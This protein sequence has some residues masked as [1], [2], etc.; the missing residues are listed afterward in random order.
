[1]HKDDLNEDLAE[2]YSRVSLECKSYLES[3]SL[4]SREDT[5]RGLL[6]LLEQLRSVLTTVNAMKTEERARHYHITY[7]AISYILDISEYLRKTNFSFE[8]IAILAEAIKAMEENVILCDVKYLDRRTELYLKV[9]K[10][11]E[12]W[13]NYQ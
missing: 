5:C 9:A 12:E 8:I 11:Y 3:D 13:E 2:L 1:M 10:I 6:A 7:N 4:V